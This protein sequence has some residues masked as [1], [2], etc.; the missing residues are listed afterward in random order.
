VF[1]AAEPT[2]RRR[3]KVEANFEVG[4]GVL[5]PPRAVKS[6]GKRVARKMHVLSENFD[7]TH[8]I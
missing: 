5:R 1:S 8:L 6:K 3:V 2:I 4:G 7:F